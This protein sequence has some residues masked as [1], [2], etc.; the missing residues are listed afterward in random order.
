MKT[1]LIYYTFGGSTKKEA[2]RL[3][4]ERDVPLYR[5]E[6]AHNRNFMA[7]FIPGGYLAMNRKSVAVNPLHINLNNY[8]RIMIGCPVWAGYPAPVFNAIVE[9]LPAGKEVELFLCSGGG[10]TQ[11]SEQ[12][13]KELIEKK[14][15]KVISY[16]NVK[17]SVQPGKMKE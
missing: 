16:R 8:D 2:E 11:K 14:G 6:E 13:T 15:C 3:S 4:A 9:Q 12:G 17:T 5:V 1:I 10:D 7:A